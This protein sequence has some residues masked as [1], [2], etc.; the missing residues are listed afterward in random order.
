[1][2]VQV[3]GIAHPEMYGQVIASFPGKP[4]MR[5]FGYLSEKNVGQEVARY[6]QAGDH[7]QVIWPNNTLS[8][9]AIHMAINYL[10]NWTG[11]ANEQV[12]YYSYEGNQNVLKPHVVWNFVDHHSCPRYPQRELI[13]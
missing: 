2:D 9:M 12:L 13:F 8:S 7:P 3:D 4:C 11:Q 6:N 1:M 5:C 10:T